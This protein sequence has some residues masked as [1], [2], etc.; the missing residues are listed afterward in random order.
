MP[1]FCDEC[2]GR[3]R[4]LRALRHGP[5]RGLRGVKCTTCNVITYSLSRKPQKYIYRARQ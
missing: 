4:P 5:L 3:L 1:R 2:G